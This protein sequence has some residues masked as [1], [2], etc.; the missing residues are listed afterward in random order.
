MTL[1]FA[2]VLAQLCEHFVRNAIW[3][4]SRRNREIE[5]HSLELGEQ[6]AGAASHLSTETPRQRQLWQRTSAFLNRKL[7]RRVLTARQ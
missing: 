6:R 4:R 1:I 2:V 7:C 5:C 3:N